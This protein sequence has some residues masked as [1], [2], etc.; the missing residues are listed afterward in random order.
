MIAG[1]MLVISIFWIGWTGHYGSISWAVP[2]VATIPLGCSI[3][4]IFISFQTF[5]VG[6]LTLKS[7]YNLNADRCERSDTYLMYAAS[8]LA[9]NTMF[10]SSVALG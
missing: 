1:P 5:I 7:I 3:T 10:R 4:L 6:E 8:A 2:G 9:A